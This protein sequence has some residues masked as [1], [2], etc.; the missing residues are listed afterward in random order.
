LISNHRER[1]G[2]YENRV[3]R[4][5]GPEREDIT[6]GGCNCVMGNSIIYTFLDAVRVI[7]KR[8]SR[9]GNVACFGEMRNQNFQCE[10]VKAK[11]YLK[12]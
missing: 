12:T 3:Q 2:V 8:T 11:D 6:E 7:R 4:V 5:F 10:N 1:S 9:V